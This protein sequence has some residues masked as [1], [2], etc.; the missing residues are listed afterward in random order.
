M[1]PKERQDEILSIVEQRERVSVEQLAA[2]LASSRETVR[3]DLARLSEAGLLRKVHGGAIRLQTAQESPFDR[4]LGFRRGEKARIARTAARLLS[5]GDSLLV[6]AG[7]TTVLFAEALAQVGGVT[8]ITNSPLVARAL[9]RGPK[10][11]EVYLLGGRFNGEVNETLGPITLEQIGG[12]STD[13]AMLTIG[14]ID[15]AGRFM[16]FNADEAYVARAMIERAR[17]TTILADGSKL[18]KTALFEVCDATRVARLV[19]DA[20]PPQPIQNVLASQGVE[21]V[22]AED[23][24]RTD[25]ADGDGTERRREL[26]AG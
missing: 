11:T 1:R 20:P 21:L 17:S 24:G 5:P 3:R 6:D 25:A 8:V 13:H 16:D 2:T 7:S 4:R 10:T 9:W 23:G 22:I 19:T 12:L 15:G 18:G 14:A 26:R